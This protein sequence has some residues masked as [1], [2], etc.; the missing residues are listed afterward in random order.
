MKIKSMT[1]IDDRGITYS[2][3]G[4]S[5]YAVVRSQSKK[6]QPYQTAVD[7]HLLLP[8]G[9]VIKEADIQ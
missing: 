2:W 7:A 1:V 6:G 3:K 5:G 8:A 4:E 9:E